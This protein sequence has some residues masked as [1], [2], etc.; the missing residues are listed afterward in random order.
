MLR[1]EVNPAC[2]SCSGTAR[3]WRLCARC[4]GRGWSDL[5]ATGVGL[6][7]EQLRFPTHRRR[8]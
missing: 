5:S 3:Q 1:L 6:L 2:R 4:C 7:A 8:V